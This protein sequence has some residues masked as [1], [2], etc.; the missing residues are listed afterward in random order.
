MS[1]PQGLQGPRTRP[2]KQVIRLKVS[3]PWDLLHSW[4]EAYT[5]GS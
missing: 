5:G 3:V 1:F 2:A 4:E